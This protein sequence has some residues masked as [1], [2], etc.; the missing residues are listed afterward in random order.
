M[1][2]EPGIYTASGC[3]NQISL[4]VIKPLLWMTICARSRAVQAGMNLTLTDAQRR[5]F[6]AGRPR[7]IDRRI[8]WYQKILQLRPPHKTARPGG[9]S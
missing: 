1:F 8:A 3:P 9:G 6:E 5:I 4:L 2:H 7:I